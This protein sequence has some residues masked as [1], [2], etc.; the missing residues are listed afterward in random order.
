M[1]RGDWQ[2]TWDRKEL[3]TTEHTY[4][5]TNLFRQRGLYTLCVYK[6]RCEVSVYNTVSGQHFLADSQERYLT[7][8]HQL[9]PTHVSYPAS[10]K[11]LQETELTNSSVANSSI[12]NIRLHARNGVHRMQRLLK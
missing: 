2:A 5:V 9:P 4:H 12:H 11:A 3:D 6:T 1:D 10:F 7:G 8:F